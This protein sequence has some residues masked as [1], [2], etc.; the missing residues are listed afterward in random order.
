MANLE[1][2]YSWLGNVI[3]LHAVQQRP[4]ESLRSF[5]QRVSQVCNTI[6][7]TSN[8]SIVVAF[9]QGVRD[10][11][12]LEKLITHDIQDVTELFSLAD[13]CARAA[14]GRSW[15]TPPAPE[16]R[17]GAK[18]DVSAADQGGSSKNKKK[19]NVG[20]NNQPLTGAPITATAPVAVGGG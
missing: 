4:G 1:S 13:K 11:K 7:R 18:P 10:D 3:D 16:A 20:G 15:H 8:T 17:I 9:H 5:I 2:V 19:K 14:E 6:P 12:I